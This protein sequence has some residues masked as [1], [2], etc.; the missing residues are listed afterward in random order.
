M[1]MKIKVTKDLSGIPKRVKAMRERGQFTLANQAHADMNLYAPMLSGD[2]RSQSYIT[3]DGD[4]WDQ[5]VWEV[6]YAR[7]QYYNY[8]A[9]FTTPGTGPNWDGKA[10]SIHMASWKKI[11]KAAMR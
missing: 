9:R 4:G 7:R 1:S 3:D 10:R 8:G 5:V 6:P 2:L 11:V